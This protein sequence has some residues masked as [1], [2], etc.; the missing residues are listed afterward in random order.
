MTNSEKQNNQRMQSFDLSPL[1]HQ[2]RARVE[3]SFQHL[4]KRAI[5]PVLSPKIGQFLRNKIC[6][7][8]ILNFRINS[9]QFEKQFSFGSPR[10]IATRIKSKDGERYQSRDW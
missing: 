8:D 3:E 1:R 9:F 2:L 4:L 5:E 6:F 10:Y 7:Y